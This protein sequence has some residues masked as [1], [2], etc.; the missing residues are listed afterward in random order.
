MSMSFI[1]GEIKDIILS[2]LPDAL[3]HMPE[4]SRRKDVVE[5]II[6]SN[7]YQQLSEL[8]TREVKNLLRNYDGM[9][10]KLR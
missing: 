7:D 8:K 5:D 1:R 10:K 2:V 6:G 4:K 9:T 3:S